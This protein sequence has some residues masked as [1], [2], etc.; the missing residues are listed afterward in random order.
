MPDFKNLV[1]LIYKKR[2]D[3]K[4]DLEDFAYR[5]GEYDRVIELLEQRSTRDR[6]SVRTH[7]KEIL[8]PKRTDAKSLQTHTALLKLA[9]TRD[10]N[11]RIVTT[12]FDRLFE[13][14]ASKNNLNIVNFAEVIL[15]SW[16]TGNAD[17][18]LKNF[19]LYAPNGS[20]KM[21]PCYDL[22]NSA[23]AIP[24][25]PEELALTLNGKKRKIKKSDFIEVFTNF[26]MNPK[27]IEN[28]FAKI[29]TAKIKMTEFISISFLPPNLKKKYLEILNLR[30]GQL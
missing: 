25:D 15:F 2:K 6:L 11:L 18:H 10:G 14:A 8:E 22:I 16:L 5:R 1:R 19:S 24:K 13:I 4:S 3:A 20:Y 27:S 17:M 28:I 23:I 7:L 29:L 26:G 21:T 9:R 30:Y 12:N